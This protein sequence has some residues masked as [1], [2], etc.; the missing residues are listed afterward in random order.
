MKN[1][2]PVSN[3]SFPSKILEKAVAC[4][5]YSHL[6][7]TK[8]LSQFQSA[9]RKSHSTETVLLK[10]D[11]DLLSAMDEGKVTALTLLDLSS[12]FDTINHSMLL[13]RLEDWVG[14]TG[15]AHDCLRYLSDW[16]KSTGYYKLGECLSRKVDLP[17]G[18]PQSSVLGPLVIYHLYYPT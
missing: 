17:F 5:L 1:Y 13:G 15:R 9:Y 8:A 14:V 10:I 2:P 7:R 18:V 12:A 3:L 6:S 11:N 16:Q 4:R